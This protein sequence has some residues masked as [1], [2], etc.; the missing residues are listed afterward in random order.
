MVGVGAALSTT[1]GGQLIQYSGFSTS[2]L[3]LGVIAMIAFA[4]LWIAV[5]ETL[6]KERSP[7]PKNDTPS[8]ELESLA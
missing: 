8:P 4:I 6:G 2:F 7:M 1:V 3:G 5:P